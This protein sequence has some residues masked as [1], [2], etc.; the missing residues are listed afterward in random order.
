M[1]FRAPFTP[2]LQ[3]AF[4]QEGGV[5]PW[6]LAGG[7]AKAN[8]I[9]A[10]QP[11]GAASLAASYVNLVTPGTYDAAPGTAPTFDSA[12]GWT[13]DGTSQY[14]VQP[15]L[16]ISGASPRT[17]AFRFTPTNVAV[18]RWVAI[19][20]EN[21]VMKAWVIAQGVAAGNVYIYTDGKDV[22]TGNILSNGLDQ[23]IIVTATGANPTTANV[24]VYINGTAVS[25]SVA[26]VN[27]GALNTT[28]ANYII[29]KAFGASNYFG[30]NVAAMLYCNVVHPN[31]AALHAA[32]AAL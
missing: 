5:V 22:L 10:Y 9:A 25:T 18:N 31:A 23:T 20:G 2:A 15:N 13:F 6:Y 19:W 12:L 30:G 4:S 27:P 3:P 26:G 21:A 1:V 29:G 7:I 24:L 16:G 32:M 28:N 11:K 14:L 8:C 17:V